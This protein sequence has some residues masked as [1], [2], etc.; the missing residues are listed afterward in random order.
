MPAA[1]GLAPVTSALF[2]FRPWYQEVLKSGDY[3][4]LAGDSGTL[5]TTGGAATRTF[6]LPTVA[7]GANGIWWFYN[8]QNNNMV[9]TAPANKLVADGNA[10]GTTATYST[11]SHMIGSLAMVIMND[12]QT[13]YYLFNLGGTTVT[14]T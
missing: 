10:T 1:P 3:S 6:T 14:I 5:F 7:L 11:A 12:A 9:I 4:V 13:I 2:G 8:L